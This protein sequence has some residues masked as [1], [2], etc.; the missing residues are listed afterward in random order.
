[1]A[2]RKGFLKLERSPIIQGAYKQWTRA[3]LLVFLVLKAHA[4]SEGYCFPGFR[5]IMDATGLTRNAIS[6]AIK[7]LEETH[8]AIAVTRTLRQVNKYRLLY[9]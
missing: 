9:K 1:M 2:D 3:D 7:R 4:D 6:T 5:R 8:E